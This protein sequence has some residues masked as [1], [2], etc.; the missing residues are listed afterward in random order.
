MAIKLLTAWGGYPHN[1]IVSLSPANE[2]G[3]ISTGQAESDLTGGT[4]YTGP[5]NE[6]WQDAAAEEPAQA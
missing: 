2:A 5:R 4:E 1:A 6:L 3:L